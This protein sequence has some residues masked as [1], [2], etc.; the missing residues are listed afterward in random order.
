MPNDWVVHQLRLTLFANEPVSFTEELWKVV[1]GETEAAARM[2]IPGGKQYSGKF[3]GGMLVMGYAGN[4]ADVILNHEDGS[5]GSEQE[6]YVP[7]IGKW[8]ELSKTF[9][10]AVTQLLS[11]LAWPINRVAF[12]AVLL[13]PVGTRQQ[14]Y[15]K[16]GQ[17]LRSVSVDPQSR[18]LSF[19]INWPRTSKVIDGLEINRITSWSSVHFAR[20]VVQLTGSTMNIAKAGSDYQCVRLEIDHNT[21]RGRKDPFKQTERLPIFDEL[22]ALADENVKTGECQ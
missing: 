1:T 20:A 8:N 5:L 19:R 2:A 21:S 22:L 14:S 16:L 15:E 18:E 6:F 3:M 13:L 17:F 10:D 7:S 11:E 12:G 4:R 9:H